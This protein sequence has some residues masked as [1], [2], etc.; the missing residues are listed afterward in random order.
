MI[1]FVKFVF[2]ISMVLLAQAA[3][4]RRS[5]GKRSNWNYS[6]FLTFRFCS[7]KEG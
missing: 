6:F 1:A 4:I 5:L 7:Y 3:P 2:A